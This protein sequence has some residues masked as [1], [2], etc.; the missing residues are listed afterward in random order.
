MYLSD[1]VAQSDHQRKYLLVSGMKRGGDLLRA[2]EKEKQ[3]I[4]KNIIPLSLE[5]LARDLVFCR[6][7]TEGREDIA[8][9]IDEQQGAFLLRRVM[10]ENRDALNYFKNDNIL[11]Q[12][13]MEALFEGIRLIRENGWKEGKA[14]ERENPRLADLARLT[15]LYEQALRD[16]AFQDSTGYKQEALAILQDESAGR[17]ILRKALGQ[18]SF[19]LLEED[20][21]RACGLDQ[22]LRETLGRILPDG[23]TSLRFFEEDPLKRESLQVLA[24]KAQLFKGFG[25]HSEALFPI[26]DMAK[27]RIPYGKA[28]LLCASPRQAETAAFALKGLGIPATLSA[29]E[30]LKG[31]PYILL[32]MQICRWV[33][34]DYSEKGLL[35]IFSNPCIRKEFLAQDENGKETAQNA[36]AGFRFFDAVTEAGNRFN[37]KRYLGWGYGWNR[38][39][40]EHERSRLAQAEE[41]KNYHKRREAQLTLLEELLDLFGKGKTESKELMPPAKWL[42]R[43]NGFVKARTVQNKKKIYF[44]ARQEALQASWDALETLGKYLRIEKDPLSLKEAAELLLDM[45]SSLT[46]QNRTEETDCVSVGLLNRWKVLDRPYVYLLGQSIRDGGQQIPESPVLTD[47]EMNEL[48]G[49]GYKPTSQNRTEEKEENLLKTLLSQRD[50]ALSVGYSTYDA[51]FNSENNPSSFY[52]QMQELWDI[53]PEDIPEFV[54]GN[55]RETADEEKAADG[56]LFEESLAEETVAE[57]GLPE[58]IDTEDLDTDEADVDD[59]DAENP[60]PEEENTPETVMEFTVQGILDKISSSSRLES[61]LRCPLAYG[62][63]NLY[64]ISVPEP[65]EKN[66]K[67]WLEAG[68]RGS[69]FHHV[70]QAY[71]AEKLIRPRGE[72]Y[73]PQTDKALLHELVAREKSLWEAVAPQLNE[74]IAQNQIDKIK[75]FTEDYFQRLH[76]SLLED[77]KGWRVLAAEQD[78]IQAR[79]EFTSFSG[80]SYHI[81]YRGSIDRLDY[82]L[83]PAEK[84][85]LLRIADYKTGKKARKGEEISRGLIMQPLLY[86]D[87]IFTGSVKDSD[88]KDSTLKEKLLKD[89]ARLEENESIRQWDLT[90][91]SFQFDFPMAEKDNEP[92]TISRNARIPFENNNMLRLRHIVTLMEQGPLLPNLQEL[93]LSRLPLTPEQAEAYDEQSVR[94]LYCK[95]SRKTDTLDDNGFCRYCQYPLLCS[96]KA[97][98]ETDEQE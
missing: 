84:T 73:E 38:Q 45:L 67:E 85:V 96:R 40:I 55:P 91:D 11:T 8:E 81:Q 83:E 19:A 98:Q 14:A 60:A 21:T 48:L 75:S 93:L 78:F 88:G 46:A 61:L 53:K 29:A 25:H 80:E 72:V 7:I 70:T 2:V 31:N 28:V 79:L 1:Y 97:G 23:V 44:K 10:R 39:F 52:R 37:G 66:L 4:A 41:K 5:K 42:A 54:I 47:E 58:D 9:P 32:M 17:T 68:D 87:A 57:N 59:A 35:S 26:W 6:Q 16:N 3:I 63:E 51:Q 12:A 89:V 94:Q 65:H 34:E 13:T 24:P 15:R 22:K 76:A 90:V 69:F 71:L 49:D 50:Y 56:T 27:K 86:R 20:F 77:P 95:N 74:G 64:K 43:I 18:A 92:I 36:M 30:S 33:L 82:A 62:L